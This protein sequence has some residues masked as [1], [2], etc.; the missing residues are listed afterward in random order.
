MT[1][2]TINGFSKYAFEAETSAVRVLTYVLCSR[3]KYNTL[4]LLLPEYEEDHRG[5]RGDLSSSI[6]NG[7][8]MECRQTT[9]NHNLFNLCVHGRAKS[10]VKLTDNNMNLELQYDIMQLV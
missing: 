9:V 8:T 10:Q 2:R 1:C 3:Y 5:I 4:L 6:W 7:N